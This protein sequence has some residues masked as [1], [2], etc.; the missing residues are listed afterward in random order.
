MWNIEKISAF[1]SVVPSPPSPAAPHHCLT[2]ESQA[3][4]GLPGGGREAHQGGQQHHTGRLR[5]A[6]QDGQVW[7]WK[8]VCNSKWKRQHLATFQR[9][10]LQNRLTD[11]YVFNCSNWLLEGWKS[12]C[13]WFS[14]GLVVVSFE[15]YVFSLWMGAICNTLQSFLPLLLC[16]VPAPDVRYYL[17]LE[18]DQPRQMLRPA[19][20][21]ESTQNAIFS[22]T[23]T[24]WRIPPLTLC[25]VDFICL[26]FTRYN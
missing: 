2:G 12:A 4:R 6:W 8:E 5:S 17:Q 7:R 23:A 25:C 18:L 16:K 15:Q 21:S 26:P 22:T 19:G 13:F 10:N 20:H 11:H 3:Q 24:Q 1:C 14:E 9:N